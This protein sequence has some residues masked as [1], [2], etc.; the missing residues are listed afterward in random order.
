M[1]YPTLL[2]YNDYIETAS[3][4]RVVNCAGADKF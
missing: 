2:Y 1:G 3:Y 4:F